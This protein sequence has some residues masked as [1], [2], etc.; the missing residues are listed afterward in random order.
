MLS[1]TECL[2]YLEKI[3]MPCHIRRHSLLVAEVA[4]L[5]G[6]LLNRNGSSLDMRLIETGALLH[7]VGKE[8]TLGTGEDHAAVGA[9]MLAGI[10]HPAA[11][12]IVREHILLE[13]SHLEGPLTESI[14]VNYS[15]KRVMHEQVVSVQTRYYDL[16]ARYAKTPRHRARLLEKLDL[17]LALE[18]KIF[19]H[20]SVGP[21]GAEIMGLKLNHTKGAGPEDD[22][23]QEAHCGIAGGREIR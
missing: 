10:V 18:E 15:D 1:R 9:E 13:P 8:R 17:Y 14:L 16:I 6:G 21:Q 19:S 2:E 11:A 20:L 5:L 3:N 4:L 22:G 12:R 23:N 7:D